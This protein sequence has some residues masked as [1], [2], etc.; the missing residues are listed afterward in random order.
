MGSSGIPT[1]CTIANGQVVAVDSLDVGDVVIYKAGE[2]I[3]MD[4]KVIKGEGVVD[5]GA[6]TG[7]AKP[8]TKEIDSQAYSGTVMQDGYIEVEVTELPENSTV[9]KLQ[10]TILEAQA[11]RGQ[12]MTLV[13][14]FAAYWTPAVILCAMVVFFIA[15]VCTDDWKKW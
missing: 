9:R 5:E 8:I 13:D 12:V 3:S 11:G 10:Q 2:M 6:L 4:G 14:E 7:E 15:Y 1:K